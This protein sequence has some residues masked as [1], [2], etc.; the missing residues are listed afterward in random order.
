M[1]L[2]CV[3]GGI[4]P[5]RLRLHRNVA[6]NIERYGL[7]RLATAAARRDA[8]RV[9]A[10]G[11]LRY[12]KKNLS[13]T[14]PHPSLFACITVSAACGACFWSGLDI[15]VS[16]PPVLDT[17]PSDRRPGCVWYEPSTWL[18]SQPGCQGRAGALEDACV[19]VCV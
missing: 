6:R 8:P 7:A 4:S 19:C 10:Q 15:F 5:D 12:F 17:P 16:A 9:L 2:T 3:H 14:S 13:V 1:W 18:D 11:A